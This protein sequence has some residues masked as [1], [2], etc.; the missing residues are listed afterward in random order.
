[1]QDKL[2]PLTYKVMNLLKN[3]VIQRLAKLRVFCTKG[4]L[5]L[6]TKHDG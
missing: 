4:T 1:M 5:F 6:G 3:Y 2:N